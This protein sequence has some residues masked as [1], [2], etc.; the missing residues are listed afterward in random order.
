METRVLSAESIERALDSQTAEECLRALSQATS[1]DFSQLRIVGEYEGVLKDSLEKL[2]GAMYQL[3]G[4]KNSAVVDILSHRYDYHNM[5][6]ALKAAFNPVPGSAESM[7]VRAS[8]VSPS[9]IEAYA[10]QEI[11]LQGGGGEEEKKEGYSFIPQK[12]KGT[13]SLP[14]YCREAIDSLVGAFRETGDP[15]GIDVGAD[16]AMFAH[17]LAVAKAA[18]FGFALDYLLHSIDFYN[19]KALL[20]AKNMKKTLRFATASLVPGGMVPIAELS[21][22]YDREPEE[23]ANAL[24]FQYFGPS[25]QKGMDSFPRKGNFSDLEKQFDNE[26]IALAKQSKYVAFG[27]EILFSYILNK[28]NEI[29]QIR[30]ILAG[31]I[32]GLKAEGIR[33][34]LR[35]NYA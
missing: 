20:R 12:E 18:D 7:Y 29:R 14:E 3:A 25:I 31:K 5:K 21:A 28:E 32:N 26:L 23:M 10:A 2:Y 11:A 33:E 34:R 8:G 13:H 24:R 17:Q 16:K 1:Y 19:V 30:L 6:A 27:P 9:D 22:N 35:D 4:E 15:Q